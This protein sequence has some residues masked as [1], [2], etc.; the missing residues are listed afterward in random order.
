MH[1]ILTG[2]CLI[3]GTERSEL[4]VLRK[5]ICGARPYLSAPHLQTRG[6]NQ[7][8]GRAANTRDIVAC[9]YPACLNVY[10]GLDH[11]K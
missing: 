8:R 11:N 6:N 5:E 2:E 9:N 3:K 7:G 4:T 1:V 10:C